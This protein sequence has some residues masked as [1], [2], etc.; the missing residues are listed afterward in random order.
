MAKRAGRVKAAGTKAAVLIMAEH[1]LTVIGSKRELL[2]DGAVGQPLGARV[3]AFVGLGGARSSGDMTRQPAL[4]P[5]PSTGGGAILGVAGQ[6][7]SFRCFWCKGFCGGDCYVGRPE[8]AAGRGGRPLGARVR[9]WR[10][11]RSIPACMT[12]TCMT[13]T[14]M[15]PTCM[16]KDRSAVWCMDFCRGIGSHCP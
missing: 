13:P 3:D 1:P 10:A 11:G 16:T 9:R 12:P 15:T 14:C 6:G 8:R 7:R 2:V 4:L 5:A